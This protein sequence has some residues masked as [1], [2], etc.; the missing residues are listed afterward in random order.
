MPR[1]PRTAA[2]SRQFI[3]CGGFGTPRRIHKRSRFRARLR[4]ELLGPAFLV[5]KFGRATNRNAVTVRSGPFQ[6]RDVETAW[7]ERKTRREIRCSELGARCGSGSSRRRTARGGW[8]RSR[9][10]SHAEASPGS[11]GCSSPL[12]HASPAKSGEQLRGGGGC[13]P[14]VAAVELRA[15]LHRR[16]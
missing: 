12:I 4:R 9:G 10:H 16:P 14:G 15:W 2:L 7:Q 8:R 11:R 1:D 6:F 3:A 5:S 13:A